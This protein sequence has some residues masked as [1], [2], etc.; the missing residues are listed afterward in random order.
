MQI[1]VLPASARTSQATIRAL[2]GDPSGP[3]VQGIYRDLA[4]VP[5][6]FKSHPNFKAVQGDMA[7]AS[8]LNCFEGSQTVV[9]TIPPTR[10]ENADVTATAAAFT[11]AVNTAIKKAVS[12]KRL[13]MVSTKGAQYDHA[14]LGDALGALHNAEVCLGDAAPE[15]VFVR[16]AYFM[17]NWATS[18][19]SVKE[20]SFFF[21]TFAP[22][23][24]KMPMVALK[25]I[26]QAC[27]DTAVAEGLGTV[28]PYIFELQGPRLYSPM[29]VKQAFEEVAAKPVEVRPIPREAVPGF[30]GKVF[31]PK[32]AKLYA[33]MVRA[34][35]PGGVMA[36][37][38]SPTEIVRK[39]KTELVDVLRGVYW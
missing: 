9:V 1:T 3:K 30:F 31:P 27:A 33:D 11:E 15:V 18:V 20:G 8:T 39:G 32:V 6:E 37:D 4:K 12:V 19:E 24:F 13:V 14:S 35:T 10:S 17:E 36:E 28:S 5:T 2:L 23:D 25:D 26:G 7:D 16:C 21:S 29:D 22:V 34:A 38:P